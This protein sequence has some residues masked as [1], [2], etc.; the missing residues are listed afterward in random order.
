MPLKTFKASEIYKSLLTSKETSATALFTLCLDEFGQDGLDGDPLGLAEDIKTIFRISDLPQVNLDKIQSMWIALTTDL[1]HTDP[2]TFINTAN[3][4]SGTAISFDIFD[5]ADP[6]ECAWALTELTMLDPETSDRLSP[7]VRRYIGEACKESGLVKVPEILSNA[8]D[9]GDDDYFE[10][11]AINVEQMEDAQVFLANQAAHKEE[12]E[13]YVADKLR[14]MIH[15]LNILP[16]Q[17]REAGWSSF[18]ED[19]VKKMPSLEMYS[20]P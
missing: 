12:I 3:A 14:S 2:S 17:N 20:S 9:F 8:A 7:D 5:P 4:L 6:Y 19:M 1:V 13:S 15:E 16:L 18:Y 11:A 10:L